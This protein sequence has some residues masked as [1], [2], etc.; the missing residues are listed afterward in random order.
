LSAIVN[1]NTNGNSKTDP[2]RQ[3]I[4]TG[5]L[6]R[7]VVSGYFVKEFCV[8]TDSIKLDGRDR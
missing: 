8:M 3:A 2:E 7:L 1:T 5:G 6:R 4:Q